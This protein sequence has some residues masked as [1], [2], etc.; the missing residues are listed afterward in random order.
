MRFR[1]DLA[2]IVH[3]FRRN[4]SMI[5]AVILVTFVSLSAVGAALML[6]YQVDR[7]KGD[8]YDKVEVSVWL[9]PTDPVNEGNCADGAVSRDQ[10]QAVKDR[11]LSEELSEYVKAVEEQSAQSVLEDYK[12]RFGGAYMADQITVDTFGPILHVEL[13]DPD[14]FE[15]ITD[16]VQA[17]PGVHRTVD[18]SDLFKELFD[19]L[20][21]VRLAALAVAGVLAVAAVLLITTTIRLSALSRRRET[22]IMRLVG[23]SNLF[24]QLPFMLEGAVAALIGS[25]LAVGTLWGVTRFWLADWVADNFQLVMG[26]VNPTDALVAAPWLVGA[27]VVLA[28]VSSALTLRR[29]TRV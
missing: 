19:L 3:G 9:C 2:E 16:A 25:G 8:W 21:K 29:F 26:S 14:K 12:E 23:A 22:G 7:I 1:V 13:T 11:L 17:L 24:I 27:A 4:A 18:Q 28:G 6:Q 20:A 5:G 15:L 10:L